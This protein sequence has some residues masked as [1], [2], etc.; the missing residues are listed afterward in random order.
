MC[1]FKKKTGMQQDEKKKDEKARCKKGA[2]LE[3]NLSAVTSPQQ[4]APSLKTS[5]E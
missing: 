1:V 4:L 2:R 3:L 5:D